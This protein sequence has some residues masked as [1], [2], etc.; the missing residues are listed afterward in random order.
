MTG[1]T[2]DGRQLWATS[3]RPLD[4]VNSASIVADNAG[5]VVIGSS[6][7]SGLTRVDQSGHVAWSYKSPAAQ[8]GTDFTGHGDS[9]GSIAVH[10][11]GTIFVTEMLAGNSS[12]L[13]AIDQTTGTPKFSIPIPASIW[14]D[15]DCGSVLNYVTPSSVG[16]VSITGDGSVYFEVSTYNGS[17]SFCDEGLV[18][19]H[20]SATA[21]L[22][23]YKV[24]STGASSTQILSS[25]SGS[26]DAPSGLAYPPV[27]SQVVQD[28][29]DD[30][31]GG[32]LALSCNSCNPDMQGFSDTITVNHVGQ[33]QSQQ[34]TLPMTFEQSLVLGDNGK[35]F[36][37]DG[38]KITQFDV[39]SGP[40]WTW[41]S[42][43]SVDLVMAT[44]GGGVIAKNTSGTLYTLDSTGTATASTTTNGATDYYA[45]SKWQ[46]TGMLGLL[47][48]PQIEPPWAPG[49]RP[50]GDA[51]HN[52]ATDPGLKVVGVR[53]CANKQTLF[54]VTSYT[55]YPIYE[56][57]D[58]NRNK[59]LGHYTVFE[60]VVDKSTGGI[61]DATRCPDGSNTGTTPCGY[62]DGTT[63]G[64]NTFLDSVFVG[65]SPES[66][67]LQSFE[68]GLPSQRK[69]PAELY[70]TPTVGIGP[71]EQIPNRTLEWHLRP[72]AEPLIQERLA[73]YNGTLV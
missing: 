69:W 1:L 71:P 8:S 68:Y 34:Y 49:G 38:T 4:N 63:I 41:N 16:P 56:L 47:Q 46:A 3:V 55:R 10:P 21:Q 22:I 39:N 50:K 61:A 18:P 5:G 72:N 36:A 65:T 2:A 31:Q 40:D 57:W 37:T 60:H 33:S 6:N 25:V 54:N 14:K 30:G 20:S 7:E 67:R 12:Q 62:A 11:D 24:L 32:V 43:D 27:Q 23:L 26:F 73:P 28:V 59:P 51:Q 29:I 53:D 42:G 58:Q 45:S 19:A 66:T 15:N 44:A 17:G 64:F 35:A 48:G 52:G 13:T 9:P 70:R